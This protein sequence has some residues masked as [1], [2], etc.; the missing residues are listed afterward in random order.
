MHPKH[1]RHVH[2]RISH[3]DYQ[4]LKA[5]ADYQ[6]ESVAA[7]VRRLI[8]VARRQPHLMGDQASA[9]ASSLNRATLS[10]PIK[11]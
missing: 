1:D 7:I 5:Q 6:G 11:R 4:F 9:P 10:S 8:R 3:D 2:F